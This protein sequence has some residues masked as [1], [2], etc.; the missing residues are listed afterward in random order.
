MVFYFHCFECSGDFLVDRELTPK[1]LI[2]IFVFSLLYLKLNTVTFVHLDVQFVT[3]Q[4]IA[5]PAPQAPIW[6]ARER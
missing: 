1:K 4:P 2:K 6:M 3:L 5:H